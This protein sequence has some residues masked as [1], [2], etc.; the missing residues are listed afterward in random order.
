[1]T[2]HYWHDM[3]D[4]MGNHYITTCNSQLRV[5]FV[6]E[7]S[8]IV[9][10]GAAL[11]QVRARTEMYRPPVWT[12]AFTDETPP[13][14][15]A[16]LTAALDADVTNSTWRRQP[17]LTRN[18]HSDVVWDAMR[19][20]GWQVSVEGLRVKATSPDGLAS[21]A[22]RPPSTYGP[23]PVPRSEAWRATVYTS[24]D[25]RRSLW[26]ADFHSATPAHLVA[27]FATALINP[28]PL[29]R[30]S[31][32]LPDECRAHARPLHEPI[33]DRAPAAPT[34]LDIRRVQAAPARSI[35]TSDSTLR[36]STTV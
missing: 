5:A 19:T 13:E 26:E 14:I 3:G 21:F 30:E 16:G 17:Y 1:M 22:Y 33:A 28:E 34:P 2:Y 32:T 24:P 7:A 10:D 8:E 12:A 9:P 4:E 15:I 20:A 29:T 35:R 27:S 25:A 36:W 6:P 31:V 11:W 23:Q 18:D